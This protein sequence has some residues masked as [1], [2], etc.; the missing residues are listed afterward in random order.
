MLLE[1]SCY[2]ASPEVIVGR[3]NTLFSQNIDFANSVGFFST[4]LRKKKELQTEKP[5][6]EDRAGINSMA[7]FLRQAKGGLSFNHKI[8]SEDEQLDWVIIY[9][10]AYGK[11]KLLAYHSDDKDCVRKVIENISS[12]VT[13]VRMLNE[14]SDDVLD[15]Y[16]LRMDAFEKLVDPD[17]TLYSKSKIVD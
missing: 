3:K 17:S 1:D 16:I 15:F 6:Y 8:A 4:Y 10:K 5:D 13:D 14:V 11:I 9:G 12:L 2:F 7:D